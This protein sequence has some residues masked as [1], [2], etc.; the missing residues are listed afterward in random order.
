MTTL[1]PASDEDISFLYSVFATTRE[2][3]L[4]AL[5]WDPE[6]KEAFLRQQ[7]AAQDRHYRAQYPDAD[8]LVI[9]HN[10]ASIGRLYVYRDAA[11]I[12]VLDVALL[13]DHR[14]VGIGTALLEE[15]LAEATT[16]GVRMTLHV[17]ASNPARRLYARLGFLMIEQHPVYDLLEWRPGTSAL[18]C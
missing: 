4:A 12:H 18:A 13:P 10:G 7:F 2:Q 11:R 16:K 5:P 6:Q 1:R 14:G 15:L 3:E 8:F 17:E 9:E